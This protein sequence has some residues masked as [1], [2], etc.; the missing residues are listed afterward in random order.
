MKRCKT[1]ELV[2][3]RD[4]GEAPLAG[5]AIGLGFLWGWRRRRR[6]FE[7]EWARVAGEE[8]EEGAEAHA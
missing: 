1:C 6:R 4:S 8:S 3:R 2:K 7:R 5:L